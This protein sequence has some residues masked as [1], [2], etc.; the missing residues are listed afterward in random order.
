MK[1]V[2]YLICI[3]F[4]LTACGSNQDKTD[5]LYASVVEKYLKYTEDKELRS[6]DETNGMAFLYWLD[7]YVGLYSTQYDIDEDGKPEL[8]I[9]VK[10]LK[11]R[12]S[13]LDI[14]TIKDDSLI[15]LTNEENGLDKIGER[16]RIQILNDGTLFY[17]GSAGISGT[18]LNI[19]EFNTEG[20]DFIETKDLQMSEV[21]EL[22]E[23]IV[24]L[25]ILDWENIGNDKNITV[26]KYMAIGDFS[27]IEG[28]WKN[29]SGNIITINE[30]EIV[31]SEGYTGTISYYDSEDGII[32]M[33]VG[34]D[35]GVGSG[36]VYI[37]KEYEGDIALV[38][39]KTKENTE[40]IIISQ[41]QVG[42]EEVYYRLE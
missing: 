6:L 17:I 27:S 30:N 7:Y 33:S 13:L 29:E 25:N 38:D 14:Y 10:D 26:D 34:H 24:D 15:K 2:I 3:S 28:K 1:K 40:R 39:G 18:A 35:G 8:L 31:F 23:K 16:M 12:Y 41:A 20:T 37:P 5:E 22:N 4:V 11:G 42:P 21:E 19:Y 9:S 36:M 32:Q